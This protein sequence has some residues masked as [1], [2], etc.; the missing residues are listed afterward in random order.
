M[1]PALNFH[2]ISIWAQTSLK[3]IARRVLEEW[4]ISESIC[5]MLC[6]DEYVY[7]SERIALGFYQ[8]L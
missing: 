5:T 3:G 8:S 6:A 7:F 1:C 2:W 4:E